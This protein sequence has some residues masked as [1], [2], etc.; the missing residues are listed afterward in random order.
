LKN[1]NN[2]KT[3]PKKLKRPLK[4]RAFFF[5]FFKSELYRLKPNYEKYYKAFC[6]KIAKYIE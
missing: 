6:R 5:A 4:S 2:K 1:Q 3:K